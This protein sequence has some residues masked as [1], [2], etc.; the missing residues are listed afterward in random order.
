M[1]SIVTWFARNP[2]AAN[3]LMVLIVLS[4]AVQ[5]AGIREEVFPET[6]TGMISVSVLFP[7]AAPE[8]VEEGICVKIEEAIQD[9]EGID[10]I[11]STSAENIGT[12]LIELADDKSA[13]DALDD[14]KSRIDAIET[15]PEEA[16]EPVVQEMVFRR[17]VVNITLS[18]VASELTLRRLA[19]RVL[20]DLLAETMVTQAELASARPYEITV[21]VSEASLRRYRLSFDQIA[22]S[23]AQSSLDLP[24]G[25]LSTRE[26]DVLIRTM[27]QR[28]TGEEIA[29]IAAVTRPDGTRL[30]IGD[31]GTVIDGFRD[32]DQFAR[33]NNDPAVQIRVFRSGDQS[34]TGLGD[35]VRQ[36]VE[37]YASRLPEG[38]ELATWQDQSRIL[39]SRLNLLKRN[40]AFGLVLVFLVLTLFL[41]LRL[42]VWISI[43]IGVSFFGTFWVMPLLGASMNMITAFGF[44][45]VLGIVVDDAIVVGESIFREQEHG[46]PG[47]AGAITGSHR[48]SIPVLFAVSTTIVAFWPMLMIPGVMGKLFRQIPIVVIP[49]LAF[50]LIESLLILPAHLRHQADPGRKRSILSWGAER[51]Q[52]VC[53]GALEKFTRRIYLPTLELA[54]RERYLAVSVFVSLLLITGGLVGAGFV[55]FSFM[56]GVEADNVVAD[57]TM[58]RGTSAESTNAAIAQ[59]ERAAIKLQAEIDEGATGQSIFRN[60]LTTVGEQPNVSDQQM[61]AGGSGASLDGAH[62]AEVNI[63][64]APSEERVGLSSDQISKRWRE[65]TGPIPGAVELTFSASLFAVGD[66]VDIL[67]KGEDLDE[68]QEASEWLKE[69]VAAIS[70]IEEVSDSFREGKEELRLTMRPEAE[71]LGLTL[72]DLARQVRQGFHGEEADRIQRGRDDV[73]VMVRYP[74]AE[75]LSISDLESMRI[76]TPGGDELPFREVASVV[77]KRGV[78]SIQRLDRRRSIHVRGSLDE[79]ETSSKEVFAELTGRILPALDARYPRIRHSFEGEKKEQSETLEALARGFIL[80]LIVI[81]ALMAIP[82]RSWLQPLIIMS[83]IPFGIVGAIL[84]HLVLGYTLSTISLCGLIALSGVVVNDN[85]VLVDFINRRRR[86]GVSLDVAIHTAGATRLRPILLTSLTTFAGLT[87]LLLEKSMQAKFMVPMA[88]SLGFGILFATFISLILVPVIY[89]IL[90]DMFRLFGVD[91]K[92][93]AETEEEHRAALEG[94]AAPSTNPW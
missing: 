94:A 59:V 38:I 52:S 57:L 63:E 32:Q 60:M 14:V 92:W 42:A 17:H 16:E 3:L 53:G 36:F 45:V 79:E 78:E 67:L 33:F 5:L 28:Y 66:D 37:N 68:L 88:V 20:E 24:G 65:L 51:A 61:N 7:G 4:G 72:S 9:L 25:S 71:Q 43:G 48:V 26:G 70:G 35:E 6:E 18:G 58:P 87:P 64:L 39:A 12:V 75:R 76:R 34:A 82:F 89:R 8:E 93:I 62:L 44:I 2:I 73:K 80:A 69:Q 77:R 21:E 15:F 22:Q 27:G 10:K 19:D 50:S 46:K 29:A 30:T 85:L 74:E 31:I 84:G 55:K 49:T 86:E 41:R 54:L 11:S 91:E 90:E 23:I 13:R 81:Y 56:P 40:A 1:N 47:L 83:A